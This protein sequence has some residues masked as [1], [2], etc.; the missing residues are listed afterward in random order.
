MRKQWTPIQTFHLKTFYDDVIA[1]WIHSN[2]DANH[3]L[4]YL[5]TINASGK[6]ISATE[7]KNENGLEFLNFRLKFKNCNKITVHIY[8]KPTNSFTYV[9]TKTC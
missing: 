4:D 6:I 1:L 9:D 3:Y 5:N 8:S 7:T 2:K